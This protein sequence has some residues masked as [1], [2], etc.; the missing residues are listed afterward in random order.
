[1]TP[2]ETIQKGEEEFR[3]RWGR[4]YIDEGNKDWEKGNK[5]CVASDSIEDEIKSQTKL[6]ILSLI[7]DIQRRKRIIKG[8][9]N[10]CKSCELVMSCELRENDLVHNQALQTEQDRLQELHDSI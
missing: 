7:A 1:M 5:N 10:R 6:F 4:F 9:C 2:L 8:N 3:Q